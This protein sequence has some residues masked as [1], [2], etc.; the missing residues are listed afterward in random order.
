MGTHGF[1]GEVRWSTDGEQYLGS[2]DFQTPAG[3]VVLSASIPRAAVFAIAQRIRSRLVETAPPEVDVGA[4]SNL[5]DQERFGKIASQ[6]AHEQLRLK[7]A[8]QI[9][10]HGVVSASPWFGEWS[11]TTADRAYD[12]IVAAGEG[13]DVC[14]GQLDAIREAAQ[15]G[16]P[17]AVHALGMFN[18]V[19]KMVA[20][21]LPYPSEMA[22]QANAPEVNWTGVEFGG[23]PGQQAARRPASAQRTAARATGRRTTA[24]V[25]SFKAPARPASVST[26][27]LAAEAPTMA[28]PKAVTVAPRATTYVPPLRSINFNQRMVTPMSAA[29]AQAVQNIPYLPTVPTPYVPTVPYGW[30]GQP[31][32]GGGGGGG[33]DEG[34][35]GMPDDDMEGGSPDAEFPDDMDEQN[36]MAEYPEEMRDTQNE[37]DGGVPDESGATV[38]SDGGDDDGPASFPDEG[39]GGG[40]LPG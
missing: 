21:D 39:V 19:A 33:S 26:P 8:E 18:V 35:Y 22:A 36:D 31:G 23:R 40:P 28:T 16:V 34:G 25:R 2:I 27:R 24:M 11:L 29:R 9:R 3:P 1:A 37:D 7:L 30:T 10:K 6:V 5:Y 17:E 12:L 38:G 15:A 14:R 4:W 32:P 13:D 20:D